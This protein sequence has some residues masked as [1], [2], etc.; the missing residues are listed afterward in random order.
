LVGVVHRGGAAAADAREKEARVVATALDGWRDPVVAVD[1]LVP[2]EGRAELGEDGVPGGLP[3]EEAPP[4]GLDDVVRSG[5]VAE[6]D[7]RLLEGLP[8]CTHEMGA[9]FGLLTETHCA[10]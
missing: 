1:E 3:R 8:Q 2:R 10:L 4:R 5:R 6:E 9:C 7:A